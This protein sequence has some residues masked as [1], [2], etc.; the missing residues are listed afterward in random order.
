MPYHWPVPSRL[1]CNSGRR[2][3]LEGTVGRS[4]LFPTC[5][6]QGPPPSP[7]LPFHDLQL[8]PTES[9]ISFSLPVFLLPVFLQEIGVIQGTPTMHT[10]Q[11]GKDTHVLTPVESPLRLA[12]HMCAPNCAMKME[13]E[14]QDGGKIA[15]SLVAI[16]A[17]PEGERIGFNYNTTDWYFNSPF[18]CICEADSCPGMVQGFSAL[19]PEQ[20]K[21]LAALV[22]RD[23]LSQSTLEQW[24]PDN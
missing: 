18:K 9:F 15:V 10:I 14:G 16:K 11:M 17:I 8:L 23:C 12:E 21:A 19:T 1:G 13:P 2:G 5:I 4:Y 3:H 7:A 6:K 22:G 24:K 20:Q